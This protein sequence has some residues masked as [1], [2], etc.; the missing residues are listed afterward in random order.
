MDTEKNKRGRPLTADITAPWPDLFN[1]ENG[2]SKLA[3]RLGVSQTT[4]GKWAR[5]IHRIPELAR[6]EL[7][8][9]CKRHGIKEGIKKF[10]GS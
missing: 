9:L 10:N 4:V 5:G 2:Q 1:C 8:R 6:K 3:Q 7:L